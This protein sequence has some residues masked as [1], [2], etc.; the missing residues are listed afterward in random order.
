AAPAGPYG[1][2]PRANP[3]AR[4]DVPGVGP[5][6]RPTPRGATRRSR[7]PDSADPRYREPRPDRS[8]EWE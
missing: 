4:P 8:D 6:A 1:P 3:A 7:R 2:L 5:S